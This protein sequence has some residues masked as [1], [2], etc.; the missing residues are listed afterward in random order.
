VV[1]T[2]ATILCFA[3]NI[4]AVVTFVSV[5]TILIYVFVGVAT[6]VSRRRDKSAVRTF[7]LPLYP[8]PPLLA[9]GGAVLA[10]SQQAGKDLLA[11]AIIYLAGLAYYFFYLRSRREAMAALREPQ[12]IEQ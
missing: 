12:L 6:I 7:R 2:C 3:S 1:G 5:L 11:V 8:L 10:L 4:V 9:I